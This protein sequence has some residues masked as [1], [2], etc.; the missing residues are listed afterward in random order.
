M[1][2]TRQKFDE[3]FR[4]GAVRIVRETGKPI[5]QVARELGINEGSG[6]S[7]QPR[8]NIPSAGATFKRRHQGF[9]HVRPSPY[10]AGRRMEPG[11]NNASRRSSPR[12]RPPDGTGTASA[13]TPGFAPRGYRRRTP[14]RRQAI[15]LARV[16]HLRHQP[17]LPTHVGI[18][19]C[20]RGFVVTMLPWSRSGGARV[21]NPQLLGGAPSSRDE[22]PNTSN[23]GNN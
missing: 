4:Q 2:E 21:D 11:S 13:S 5:A 12:P 16:L 10:T 18:L 15:A 19:L 17:N 8:S 3:D 22:R 7:L 23:A 1:V 6:Q 9:T 14:R 20:F